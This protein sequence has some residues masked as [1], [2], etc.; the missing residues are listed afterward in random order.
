[1]LPDM[2]FGLKDGRHGGGVA[3]DVV[4]LALHILVQVLDLQ[5]LAG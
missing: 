2:L 1:M 4:K 3:A 5:D